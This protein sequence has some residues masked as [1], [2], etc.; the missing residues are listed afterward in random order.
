MEVGGAVG[1][2]QELIISSQKLN[3][4]ISLD[5]ISGILM[6]SPRSHQLGVL[7]CEAGCIVQHLMDFVAEYDLYLPIDLGSK[8]SCAIGGTVSTNAGGMRVL[9]YGSWHQNILGECCSFFSVQHN[10]GM[11]VV[12]SNGTT[13][14]MLRTFRKDNCGYHL[15]NLFIGQVSEIITKVQQEPKGRWVTSPKLRFSYIQV[16]A[17]HSLF[18]GGYLSDPF[19]L[20]LL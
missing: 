12:L 9:R 17:P 13:I 6:C 19:A 1:L 5:S 8:G 18:S 16:L 14:D 15:K 10:L 7:V 3:R 20:I 4:V 2:S 11:E